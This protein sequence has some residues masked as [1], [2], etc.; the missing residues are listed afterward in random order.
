VLT[1]ILGNK[2]A[3]ENLFSRNN[4]PGRGATTATPT[5]QEVK[6]RRIVVQG[7]SGKKRD[8]HFNKKVG[9]EA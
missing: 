5:T 2:S 4:R 6:I 8:F 3:S 1:A 9:Q 7:Q